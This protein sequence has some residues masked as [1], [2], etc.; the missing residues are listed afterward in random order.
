MDNQKIDLLIN[1][2]TL[3]EKAGLVSGKDYWFTEP[4]KHLGIKSIM[5]TDGPTGL[6]KQ[7]DGADALGLNN[8]VK[9]ISFPSSALTASSFDRSLLQ[10]IGTQ[11][12]IAAKANHVQVLLGPGINIKRSP[13]GGRNFEYFSEDPL[14]AGELGKAYVT[15]VQSQGVGVSVK[16]FAAN[17]RENQRFTVS[18]NIDERTLREIYL[19][20]FENIVKNARPATIMCSYNA[21]NHHLNSQNQRLLTDILRNEWGFQGLVMSDWGAVADHVKALQ[22]GLDLEMPGKGEASTDEIVEAVN[23]GT[24]SEAQ[25]D[26]AVRRILHLIFSFQVQSDNQKVHYDLAEQHHFARQAAEESMVLLK[27]QDQILPLQQ[28]DS[29]AIVGALAEHPRYQGGGSSHVNAFKITTPFEIARADDSNVPYAPGYTLEDANVDESLAADAVNLAKRADKVIFFA[30]VPEQDESEGF[31]KQE[32]ELPENQN[33]LIKQIASVNSNVVVVLQNG[34]AV[35]MPWI[36]QVKAV[37]ETY[38]AGEAVGEATWNVLKGVVNPSGKLAET[39]PLR[40]EDTPAYGTFDASL[41][42]ENYREGIFVGYR[43][44]DAKKQPVLFPF[45]YGLSYTTFDYHDLIVNEIDGHKVE[46]KFKVTNSGKRAGKEIAQIYVANH[47]SLI[48]K[49]AKELREFKKIVLEPGETEQVAVTLPRR[50]FSW[51]NPDTNTWQVDNGSYDIEIGQSSAE[52]RL[53]QAIQLT[54]TKSKGIQVTENTYFAD[55]IAHPKLS[56][57]L[58]ASGLDKLLAKLQESPENAQ[59]LENIPLRSAVMLGANNEQIA[60][61]I[62]LANQ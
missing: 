45:G 38:L 31:D 27:N 32:L 56:S 16:H 41:E 49:P 47:V 3:K 20:A 14:I 22:A 4:I 43:Y 21:V 50:A 61:F 53:Q 7:A 2:L 59:L 35:T 55:I 34:S 33:A 17:N 60:K 48:E 11:L 40:L 44:Y 28:S 6:R 24:L 26:I 42:E 51:Y 58:Q 19:A 52:I 8:S 46:V 57:A 1:Q 39:F 13:L 5:M 9:A 10:K 37:L 18:S 62:R 29:V 23:D 30:G 15:G 12:G 54:W 36:S 25:L